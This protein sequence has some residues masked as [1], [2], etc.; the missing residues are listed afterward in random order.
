VG[1]SCAP[2]GQGGDVD[3]VPARVRIKRNYAT[4]L[5]AKQAELE[6]G[7]GEESGPVVFKKEMLVET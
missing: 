6:Q 7:S 5:S 1:P 3:I 4:G 2:R